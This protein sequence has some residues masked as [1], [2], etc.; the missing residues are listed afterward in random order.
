M[1]AQLLIVLTRAVSLVHLKIIRGV[2]A[3]KRRHVAISGNLGDN[4]GKRYDRLGFVSADNGALMGE[5]AGG[6]QSSIEEDEA[7]CVPH[8]DPTQGAL[9]GPRNGAIDATAIDSAVRG[10]RNHVA[11]L[12]ATP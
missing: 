3:R 4:R 11:H 5:G 8:V 2:P 9:H 12:T 1:T 10:E 6:T 7:L